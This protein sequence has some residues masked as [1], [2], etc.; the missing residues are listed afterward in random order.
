MKPA[1]IEIA[2]W[3]ASVRPYA[4]ARF[5]YFSNEGAGAVA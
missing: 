2:G 1:S 3:R 4:F 5:F